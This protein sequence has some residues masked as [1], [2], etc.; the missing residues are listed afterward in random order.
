MPNLTC[1]HRRTLYVPARARG[2]AGI[3]VMQGT[4]VA[5]ELILAPHDEPVGGHGLKGVP[6]V[7]DELK[8]GSLG[9]LFCESGCA[10]GERAGLDLNE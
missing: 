6:Q 1:W 7:L 9:L 5:D 4:S 3:P 2:H 8:R 10:C